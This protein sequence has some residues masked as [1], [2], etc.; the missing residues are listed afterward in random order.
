MFTA[1]E[2]KILLND[3]LSFFKHLNTRGEEK[4]KK[5]VTCDYVEIRNVNQPKMCRYQ[6]RHN[7]YV[8]EE[9]NEATQDITS[10]Y[11]G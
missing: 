7:P 1:V 2:V 6:E 11:K 9:F 4:F 10:Q 8:R 3:Y 5:N